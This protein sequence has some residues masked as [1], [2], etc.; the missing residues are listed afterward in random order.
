MFTQEPVPLLQFQHQ[1]ILLHSMGAH[2]VK[3]NIFI[4]DMEFIWGTKFEQYTS[5]YKSK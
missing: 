1:N 2:Y 5:Y 3:T 4:P